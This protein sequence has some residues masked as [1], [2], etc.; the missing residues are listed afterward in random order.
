MVEVV[1]FQLKFE[2]V[3]LRMSGWRGVHGS[4]RKDSIGEAH[5]AWV[6][7]GGRS[8]TQK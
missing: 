8:E 5:G 2:V 3:E 1:K 4:L 6:V 7:T